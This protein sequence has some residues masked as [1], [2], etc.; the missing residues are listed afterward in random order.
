MS[1]CN[2]CHPKK[3]PSQF[4]CGQI[5][6]MWGTIIYSFQRTSEK[7]EREH[8]PTVSRQRRKTLEL[9]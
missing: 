1:K 9:G 6:H 3:K 8:F 5:R 2:F 4:I 7:D